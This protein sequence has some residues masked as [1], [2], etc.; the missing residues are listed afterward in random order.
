M[1]K[2][3]KED[4][5]RLGNIALKLNKGLAIS[6]PL[7]TGIATIGSAFS[8]LSPAAAVVAV[9]AGAAATIINTVEH[10]AQVG[11]V[12]E[13]YRNCGGFFELLEESSNHTLEES[14]LEKREHGEVFEMKMALTLGRSLS[15]LKD[16]AKKPSCSRTDENT[17][18]E[19]A[20][21]LF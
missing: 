8:G 11:M 5:E 17:F 6:G 13:M 18:G 3:D 12:F 15:E 1:R 14:E 9:V 10:G 4:Y 16:L 7:L 21:K 19:F 2:K 20:S